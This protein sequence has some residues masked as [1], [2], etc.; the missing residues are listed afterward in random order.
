MEFSSRWRHLGLCFYLQ[1]SV[2][3]PGVCYCLTRLSSPEDAVNERDFIKGGADTEPSPG[4]CPTELICIYIELY[5][6]LY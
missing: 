6:K 3:V 2:R 5:S 1:E 4:S